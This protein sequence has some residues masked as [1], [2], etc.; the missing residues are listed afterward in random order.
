MSSFVES[1]LEHGVIRI[2]LNRP[3][4]R[5]A[6]TRDFIEQVLKQVLLVRERPKARL[7][8]FEAAGPVFCAGMDLGEMRERAA[9]DNAHDEWQEDSRVL[10]ELFS[11]IYQL[12]IPT[13]AVVQGAAIAGGMGLVLACD[14]VIASEAA[15][16]GLP[17]PARG[18]TAAIVTPLL[19]H[20]IGTGPA[21]QLLLSGNL[22]SARRAMAAGLCLSVVAADAM[23]E[24]V[25]EQIGRILQGAPSAL[26]ITK[27]HLAT[28]RR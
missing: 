4:K 16:F 17:E 9:S 7:L 25:N 23:T 10:T 18:I 20:R 26:A 1:S 19:I 11:A 21:T 28:S 3:E 2:R 14:L 15:T 22:W 13:L 5:N 12:E 8:V 6:L 24:S 27:R